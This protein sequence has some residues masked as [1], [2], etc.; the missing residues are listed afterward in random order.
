MQRF[1]RHRNAPWI[2]VIAAALLLAV[3]MGTRSS[4]GLFLGPMNSATAAGMATLGLAVALG[5][6]AW[7]VASPGCAFLARR[8][9]VGRV[10]A[11]GGMVSSAALA[12]IGLATGS[13]S[14]TSAIVLYGAAGA[15]AG[16]APLLMGVVAQRLAPGRQ[17]VGLGVVSAGGSAGQFVLAPV[18]TLLLAAFDW[19]IALLVFAGLGLA[20]LPLSRAFGSATPVARSPTP[21]VPATSLRSALRDPSYW[22]ITAGFVVCGFHVSFL[23]THMPNV[24]ELCGLP[25]S[26]SGAWLAILGACNIV[27]SLASGWLSQR[28]PMKALLGSLYALRAL[29]VAVFIA[30][31]PSEA[32][33]IGFALWMGLTYM[34]TV[35]P[36][37]GLIMKLYGARNLAALFGITMALHQVGSFLGAWLGGLELETTGAL[38]WI[39]LVDI[40]LAVTAAAVHLPIREPE[41]QAAPLHS[42]TPQPVAAA[43]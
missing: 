9:G 21:S 28:V 16:S 23:T 3:A 19:R 31:P 35:P 7:G 11:W 25:V 37:S 8:Y 33:M 13:L 20:A 43:S 32:V 18:A 36:T 30:L 14:L 1:A 27:G 29:G 17:G 10:V 6:L 12:A 39:W 42:S 4:L 40:L 34:A 5:Q 22:C 41:V 38:H 2:T 26:L 24:I 15:A